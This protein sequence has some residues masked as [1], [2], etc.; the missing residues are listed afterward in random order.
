MQVRVRAR[1]TSHDLHWG[2]GSDSTAAELELLVS[3]LSGE[4]V[5]WRPLRGRRDPVAAA[6]STMTTLCK[7]SGD[8][9]AVTVVRWLPR[10]EACFVTAHSNGRLSFYDRRR[11]EANEASHGRADNG[12][13]VRPSIPSSISSISIRSSSTSSGPAL[14]HSPCVSWLVGGGAALNALAFSSD[15]TKLATGG[16]DG[17]LTVYEIGAERL[18]TEK[19]L[20]RLGSY[21]GGVLCLA[22]SCDDRLLFSGGEDDM[23][24]VWSVHR[25]AV[26]ARG[27]G[28]RSWVNAVAADPCDLDLNLSRLDL[29]GRAS[30]PR[31]HRFATGGADARLLLW[32]YTEEDNE[33]DD[34]G[35]GAA[36]PTMG[37]AAP[38]PSRY[39]TSQGAPSPSRYGASQASQASQGAAVLAVVPP[40]AFKAVPRLLPMAAAQLHLQPISSL[41]AGRHALLTACV[42]GQVK[43]W[44]R[45]S[46]EEHVC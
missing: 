31:T 2:S 20:L 38:S 22:W 11:P 34:D 35:G 32:E 7:E 40:P 9:A 45:P 42:G 24:S 6:R 30:R 37:Q 10:L 28:H 23:V 26:V 1:P 19:V 3:F 41:L 21:F 4:V 13:R 43:T 33:A 17:V 12:R 27:Q 5:L 15:G 16:A 39:G 46:R 25:G 36:D 8:G 14:R 18:P 44:A 29:D